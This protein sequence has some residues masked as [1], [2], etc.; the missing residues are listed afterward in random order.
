MPSEVRTAVYIREDFEKDPH[1][2]WKSF[3]K[4]CNAEYIAY[5]A[6]RKALIALVVSIGLNIGT[7][8]AVC[9]FLAKIVK[10]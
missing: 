8:I 3:S 1:A 10:K 7:V 4:A 6:L 9:L 5:E 2:L